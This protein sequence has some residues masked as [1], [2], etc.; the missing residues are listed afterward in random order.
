MADAWTQVGWAKPWQPEK[1]HAR[2]GWAVT[3]MYAGPDT[4]RSCCGSAQTHSFFA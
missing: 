1:G 4:A 3:L 2:P